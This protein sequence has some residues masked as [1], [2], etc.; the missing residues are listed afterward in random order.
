M[1]TDLVVELIMLAVLA[2]CCLGYNEL[3]RRKR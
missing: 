2:L 3:N 1:N